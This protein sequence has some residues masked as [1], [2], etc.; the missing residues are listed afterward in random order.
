MTL[1]TAY[2][3]RKQEPWEDRP[4]DTC[5]LPSGWTDVII[6]LIERGPLDDGDV[7]SK[8]AR[9]ALIHR[10]FA[11]KAIVNQQEAGNLATY[12]GRELYKQLVDAPTLKEAIAKRQANPNFQNDLWKSQNK[13]A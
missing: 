4:I 9:D 7:P 8:S 11:T 6:A 5:N 3:M 12:H 13:A 10:G 1:K 2:A